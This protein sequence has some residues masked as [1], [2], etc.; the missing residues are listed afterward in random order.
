MP[1]ASDL[2]I[3]VGCEVDTEMELRESSGEIDMEGVR[4]PGTYPLDTLKGGR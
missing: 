4:L 1:S 2:V 3:E